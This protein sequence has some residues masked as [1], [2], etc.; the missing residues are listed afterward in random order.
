M[1]PTGSKLKRK[2]GLVNSVPP[3]L[4]GLHGPKVFEMVLGHTANLADAGAAMAWLLFNSGRLASQELLTHATLVA[5]VGKLVDVNAMRRGL[6]RSRPLFP[7]PLGEVLHVYSRAFESTLEE[8][9]ALVKMPSFAEDVWVSLTVCSLNGVAG[10]SRAALDRRPTVVHRRAACA[11]RGA[12]KRSLKSVDLPRTAQEIEKELSARYLSYTGEEIP[13][14]Q[15]VATKQ[16]LPAL[17]PIEHGGSVEAVEL[18]SRGTQEFLLN[19]SNSMLRKLRDGVKPTAKVH[20]AQNEELDICKLL[21]ERRICVWIKDSDVRRLGE[22][23]I[24]NGM[25]AAGKSAY[26]ETEEIQR[27]IMNLVP[28]NGALRQIQG[29]TSDLPGITQYLSMV[30][31]QHETLELF[32][33]DMSSAFYLFRIPAAWSEIMAFNVAFKVQRWRYR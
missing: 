12:V 11:I 13:K 30:L 27:L 29:V 14:M 15:V 23:Q 7:I 24:L 33:S 5:L 1:N 18:V 32:Q 8:F 16:I 17:P 2:W 28:C 10:K 22:Q 4:E 26:L 25:F 3:L 20:L 19:P 6:V 21:V 9:V 31:N